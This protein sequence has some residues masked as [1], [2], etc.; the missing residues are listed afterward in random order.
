MTNETIKQASQDLLDIRR[1][2]TSAWIDRF[3]MSYPYE[4]QFPGPTGP[5]DST[6]PGAAGGPAPTQMGQPIQSTAGQ[7]QAGDMTVPNSAGG[8]QSAGDGA[9]K[10][11]LW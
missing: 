1:D 5:E 3:A 10:T 2:W 9:A 11:T 4:G 7:F 6:T 8:P